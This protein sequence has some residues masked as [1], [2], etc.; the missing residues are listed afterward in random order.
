MYQFVR[1]AR[2]TATISRLSCAFAFESRQVATTL[3]A[4]TQKPCYEVAPVDPG[5]P[6]VADDIGWIDW[7]TFPARHRPRS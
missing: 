5:Q 7:M 6:I 4:Q 1:V 3:A 2:T